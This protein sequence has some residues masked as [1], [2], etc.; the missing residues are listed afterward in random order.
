VALIVL[1]TRIAAPPERVFDLSRSVELHLRST[2]RTGE[3]AIAGRTSGLFE[4]HDTVTWRAKH[5]GFW[6]TLTVA[7]TEYDRPYRFV[8]EMTRGIFRSMRHEHLFLA[9][10]PGTRMVDRFE[11]YSPLGPLGR[12]V[13]WIYLRDYLA[14]LMQERNAMIRAVAESEKDVGLPEP[15]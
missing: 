14:R 9:E 10:H 13:D 3:Q 5:L 11:F 2:A 6:Q 15:R 4:L 7:I 12:F 8:D 1:E